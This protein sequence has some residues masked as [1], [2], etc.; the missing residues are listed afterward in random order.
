M[1]RLWTISK[2]SILKC[3]KSTDDSND[4]YL[5]ILSEKA[6]DNKNSVVKIQNL[7]VNHESRWIT[8][9]NPLSWTLANK[10]N[11]SIT[12]QK[13]GYW[14]FWWI[15]SC[16]LNKSKSAIPNLFN[17]PELLSSASDKVNMF[18]KNFSENSNLDDSR[19]CF[20]F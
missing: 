6:H 10:T 18:T 19:I 16:I 11:K 5:L 12:F 8:N 7:I 17:D 4:F 9:H 20:P 2:E 13:P 15:A 3:H 14:D 1:A